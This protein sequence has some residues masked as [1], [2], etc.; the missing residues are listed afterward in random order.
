MV[1]QPPRRDS[2]PGGGGPECLIVSP[3]EMNQHLRAVIIAPMT[4]V[5]HTHCMLR[6]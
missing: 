3:N 6:L 4:T 5:F 1:G 2:D